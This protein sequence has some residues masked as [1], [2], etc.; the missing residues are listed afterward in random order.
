MKHLRQ[1]KNIITMNVELL[2]FIHFIFGDA[3][4]SAIHE[5]LDV[6]LLVL[7]V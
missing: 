6:S 3:F 1:E 4:K 7:L 2:S 5:G